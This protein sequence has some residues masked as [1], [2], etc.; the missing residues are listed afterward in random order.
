[1]DEQDLLRLQVGDH[2]DVGPD[3]AGDLGQCRGD[4]ER[5]AGRDAHQLP[6]G[7]DHLLG[8][9]TAR[10]ERA[11]LVADGPAVDVRAD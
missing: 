9:P 8:V 3:R 7:D 1:V 10:E 6:C 2:E 5:Y 11:H 4:G